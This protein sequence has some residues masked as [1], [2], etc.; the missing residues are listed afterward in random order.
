MNIF[1]LINHPQYPNIIND[2]L[3]E[4]SGHND[5]VLYISIKLNNILSAPSVIFIEY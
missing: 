1:I 3:N 5:M 4:I 2:V